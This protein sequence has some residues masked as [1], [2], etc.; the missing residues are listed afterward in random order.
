M[1]FDVPY[2][3]FLRVTQRLSPMEASRISATTLSAMPLRGILNRSPQI[4]Y[5]AFK[6]SFYE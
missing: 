6:R 4:I 2:A 1:L 5:N 3:V